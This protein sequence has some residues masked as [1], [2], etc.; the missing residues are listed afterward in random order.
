MIIDEK[1]IFVFLALL[2]GVW[3]V[4]PMAEIKVKGTNSYYYA[5]TASFGDSLT[6]EDASSFAYLYQYTGTSKDGCTVTSKSSFE[7]DNSNFL[8]FVE[9]GNCS[10]ESK[11]IIAESIGATGIVVYNSLEGI[12]QGNNYASDTD[13]DCDNGEGYVDEVREIHSFVFE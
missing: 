4:T 2:R 5:A 13:Y 9:R 3:S 7:H 6:S 10:F 11:A 8:M 12:Y 1:F